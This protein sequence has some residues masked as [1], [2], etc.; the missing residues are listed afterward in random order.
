MRGRNAGRNFFEIPVH[1][2]DILHKSFKKRVKN[3]A[4]SDGFFCVPDRFFKVFFNFFETSVRVFKAFAVF[5]DVFGRN[6]ETSDSFFN[7]SIRFFGAIVRNSEETDTKSDSK[8]NDHDEER[9]MFNM[10]CSTSNC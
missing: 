8:R 5:F 2:F 10:Q 6:F 9:K 4:A 1:C 7:A 3:C